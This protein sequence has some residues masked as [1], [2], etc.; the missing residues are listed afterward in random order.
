M[1]DAVPVLGRFFTEDELRRRER[2]AVIGVE[3]AK[4]LFE[5]RVP[6]GER[7]KFNRISF[8][9]IGILPAKGSSGWQNEDDRVLVPYTTAMYRVLGRDYVDMFSVEAVSAEAMADA[10]ESLRLGLRQ[11]L[12]L[13]HDKEDNFQ[14]S[15]MADIQKAVQ[16]TS[17][18]L[19]ALLAAIA[20]IS[21]LVG[22]IGIMNIMLVSVTERTREIGLRKALGARPRDILWQF[23]IEA[24][25]VSLGGGFLGML[26]GAGVA[27]GA[28]RFTGWAVSIT[29]GSI[30][31]ATGFSALVGLFFGLWPARKAARLDPITA[32]RYE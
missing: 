28:A 10:Q 27:L 4:Q 5:G 1:R 30:F 23:L 11:R 8:E 26:L 19:S 7:V 17:Q 22:G 24:V 25:T 3:L 9:I 15:N 20:A 21:L 32:L 2:V 18:T 31:L 12:R 6:L 13:A 29:P 16:A 14:V